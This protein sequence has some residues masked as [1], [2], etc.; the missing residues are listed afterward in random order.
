MSACL[1]GTTY[2]RKVSALDTL[3]L[4]LL[5]IIPGSSAIQAST[6]LLSHLFRLRILLNVFPMQSSRLTSINFI[7]F[8]LPNYSYT[9]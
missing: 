3:E 6:Q 1:Y 2:P 9:V 5:G 8:R 7:Y 4:E